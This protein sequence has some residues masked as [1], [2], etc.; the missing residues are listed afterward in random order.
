MSDPSSTSEDVRGSRSTPRRVLLLD[1][2]G[3]SV[4]VLAI[5]LAH[6]TYKKGTYE[7]Y[8][9]R[10]GRH[11]TLKSLASVSRPTP[12]REIIFKGLRLAGFPE[13]E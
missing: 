9:A 8:L 1:V 13:T 7:D 2:G 10:R 12:Q 3:T 5:D 6:L 11:L 4:K